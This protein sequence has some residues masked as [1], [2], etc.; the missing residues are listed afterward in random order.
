MLNSIV[1]GVA[2]I[3]GILLSIFG[4][5]PANPQPATG[6]VAVQTSEVGKP[7]PEEGADAATQPPDAAEAQPAPGSDLATPTPE[8]GKVPPALG[9]EVA[10]ELSK[11][12][13]SKLA[14]EAEPASAAKDGKAKRDTVT[15]RVSCSLDMQQGVVRAVVSTSNTAVR[16]TFLLSYVDH[17]ANKIDLS[18]S[19]DFELEPET[20]EIL[21]EMDV[22]VPMKK[23]AFKLEVKDN[24][25]KVLCR[26]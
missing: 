25:G 12:P 2:S 1:P 3:A 17:G 21:A 16:G 10:K 15:N 24:W 18:T 7:A 5:P 14:A 26:S 13:K 20:P 8:I 4:N 22:D 11:A 9:P 23:N 6:P 19:G